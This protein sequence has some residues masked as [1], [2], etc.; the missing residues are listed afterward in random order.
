MKFFLYLIQGR[1]KNVL[2]YSYLQNH[3]ADLIALTF[4]EAIKESELQSITNIFF[5][6]STWAEGR[7][8][9]LGFAKNLET[10]YL[11]YIFIDDDVEFIEGD[12]FSF[13]QKLLQNK[14][15]IGV[16]LLTIIKNTNRYNAKLAIQ[17]PVALDT[18]VQAFHYKVIDESVVMPLETKFDKLSW[19]YACEINQFLILSFY[20]NY[21]MQFNDIVVDNVG[22][23]WDVET[24]VST[25][26]NSSYL[27][28]ISSDGLE[29]IRNFIKEKYGEQ[30]KI[31]NSLFHDNKYPKFNYQS[32]G[33][34]LEKQFIKNFRM[35]KF[36]KCIGILII[37]FKLLFKRYPNNLI[38]NEKKVNSFDVDS[39]VK[40]N[41]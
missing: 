18:Q 7:N 20:K 9:Q 10:K 19:W 25:D 29:Q 40:Q 5:P 30:P 13:E 35:G 2:K 14:P 39:S 31:R 6:K 22:H 26:L 12:F 34:D 37:A 21:V 3:H 23:F 17:H 4:D 41:Q 36:K 38:I 8:K 1:K 28:G 27:G 16:P 32:K 15:A 11:Y 24:N 33:K